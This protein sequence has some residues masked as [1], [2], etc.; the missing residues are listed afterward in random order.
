MAFEDRGQLKFTAD[1]TDVEKKLAAIEKQA[2]E[3]GKA[4]KAGTATKDQSN[5]VQQQT[6]DLAKLS[7]TTKETANSTKE[8]LQQKDKLGNVLTLT[9][10]KLGGYAGS[11]GNVLELTTVLKPA[12]IALIGAMVGISVIEKIWSGI[13]A[14][15]EKAKKITDALIAAG[16]EQKTE[17]KEIA[18][19]IEKNLAAQ[20]VFSDKATQIALGQVAA[21]GRA[22]VPQDKAVR[23][24]SIGARTGTGVQDLIFASLGDISGLTDEEVLKRSKQIRGDPFLE[25]EAQRNIAARAGQ[26]TGRERR[27]RF[28]ELGR[29]L[30][31]KD[32]REITEPDFLSIIKDRPSVSRFMAEAGIASEDITTMEELESRVLGPIRSKQTKAIREVEIARDKLEAAELAP[33]IGLGEP[34]SELARRG[35]IRRAQEA[36][37][38]AQIT[39]GKLAPLGAAVGEPPFI[40]RETETILGIPRG[41]GDLGLSPFSTR[42]NEILSPKK[43]QKQQQV[44][45]YNIQNAQINAAPTKTDFVDNPDP[46]LTSP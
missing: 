35:R 38:E 39:A 41:T 21:L 42:L 14:K 45:T 31:Q 29:R 33:A 2:T 3:L 16:K 43:E 28:D 20:G 25:L 8:L 15:M 44:I 30:A 46:G 1:V 10:S 24:A 34:S 22:G 37:K 40:P 26:V 27:I 4:V 13:A 12:T 23:L 18:G 17:L 32:I 9:G 6:Q 11:L 19:L 5:G 36:L 7:R